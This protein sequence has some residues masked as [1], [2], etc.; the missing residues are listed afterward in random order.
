ME[1]PYDVHRI[2]PMILFRAHGNPVNFKDGI[3]YVN[4]LFSF[5]SKKLALPRSSVLHRHDAMELPI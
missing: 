2:D 3:L 5:S 1:R 4:V